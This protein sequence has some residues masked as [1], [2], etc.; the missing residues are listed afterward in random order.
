LLGDVIDREVSKAI[1]TLPK[2]ADPS[3][4][5]IVK[6]IASPRISFNELDKALKEHYGV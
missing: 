5:T 3:D 1:N 6:P 4:P 2:D